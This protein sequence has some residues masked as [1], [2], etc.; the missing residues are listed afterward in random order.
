MKPIKFGLDIDFIEAAISPEDPAYGIVHQLLGLMKSR[1]VTPVITIHVQ[2]W[3]EKLNQGQQEAV[4]KLKEA[5]QIEQIELAEKAD[6]LAEDY[7]MFGLVPRK[8]RK[9]A[10]NIAT[11]ALFDI[12]LYIT[13]NSP[14]LGRYKNRQS[15]R[16]LNLKRHAYPIDIGS[17]LHA[18]H[19]LE[20]PDFV[21]IVH[22]AQTDVYID[23]TPTS[24]DEEKN[25]VRRKARRILWKKKPNSI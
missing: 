9:N 11:Y 10:Q 17:P 8:N 22:Q 6:Q 16:N 2:E 18:I 13:I 12:P 24:L 5:Y 20:R 19:V 15:L 25:K 14:D 1:R 7:L 4:T 23:S 21:E 3:I